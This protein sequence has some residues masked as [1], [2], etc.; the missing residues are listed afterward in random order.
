[1][2][3]PRPDLEVEIVLTIVPGWLVARRL[4]L[5]L[6]S[7]FEGLCE[8]KQAAEERPASPKIS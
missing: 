4:S 8:E 1:V 5:L 3:L 2:G 6:S 7:S